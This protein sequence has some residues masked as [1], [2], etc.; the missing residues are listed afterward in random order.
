MAFAM[1]DLKWLEN[2]DS[3]SHWLS[4]VGIVDLVRGQTNLT[5]IASCG[6]TDDLLLN[7]F[8]TLNQFLPE[9][10][11]PGSVFNNLDRFIEASISA[12]SL[13]ALFERDANSLPTLLKIFSV[14]QFLADHLIRDPESFDLLR[15]TEGQAVSRASLL[16][17]ILTETMAMI[18][19][20][21][22]MRT[23]RHC[24]QR[25]MLRIAY[26]DFIGRHSLEVVTEQLS[27]LAE[28]LMEAALQWVRQSLERKKPPPRDLTGHPIRFTVLALGKLGGTEL[29]YSSDID[30]IFLADIENVERQRASQ[31]LEFFER[32]A[33]QFIK[34]LAEK[35]AD[36][37]VYRVDMR[38]RPLGSNGSLVCSP[39]VAFNYYENLGRTWERQAY[40]KAR[41][42]AGN[43][44]LGEKF[45]EE[46]QPWIFRRYL[47]RADIAGIGV[48]KRRIEKRIS[49]E[50][51]TELNVKLGPGGIRD[52]EFV[53]QF[54]Q[55][56]NGGDLKSIRCRNT[57]QAI[58]RLEQAS[59]LNQQEA[60]ILD[61][62][63]R[64]LRQVEHFLQIMFDLQTH[65]L[66]DTMSEV[67][68]LAL[69]MGFKD[70]ELKRA[71]E[72]LRSMLEEK[73]ERIRRIVDHLLHRAFGDQGETA[74]ETDLIL[75]PD[76]LPEMID[77]VLI[78]H[79]FSRPYDAYQRLLE[80]SKEKFSFLSTRR[81]RH[82]LA[83]IAPP[84]L[85]AISRTPDPDRTLSQLSNVS[86]SLGGKAVL[87][88]LF[89]FNPPSMQLYVRLCACSPY[90]VELLTG[91]PGMIDELLDSL[92]LDRLP[93]QEELEIQLQ[94]LC[95]NAADI[96]PILLSF[97]NSH[98]LRVGTRDILGKESISNTHRA[99][100]DIAE[101]TLR[102]VVQ[103]EYQRLSHRYGTPTLASGPRQGEECGFTIIALGKLGG[104][105]PN[106]HSDLDILFLFE[107][108]GS[109]V[110]RGPVRKG[111]TTTNRHFYNQ[112]SQRLI[113]TVSK[114]TPWGRLYEIDAR[115]RPTGQS[116]PL[117]IAVEDLKNYFD[118][119]QGQ[120]WERQALC[121]ARPIYGPPELQAKTMAVIRSIITDIEW[122]ADIAK[123]I[124]EMRMRLQQS[125]TP[126]NIKR[127]VGGT[128][129]IEFSIQALQIKHARHHSSIIIPG[130][131]AALKPL[132]EIGAL[133][134]E[135]A[136]LMDEGYRF[137]RGIESGLRL[138]NTVARHDFPSEG[139][140]LRTLE[141]L[142]GI[143]DNVPIA[144][145]CNQIRRQNR[146]LITE[147]F[148]LFKLE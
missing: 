49:Q 13:G 9:T 17:E 146:L 143:H 132:V 83:A 56:L 115:L 105:E 69:R 127:G 147:L 108:D 77:K 134:P 39:Q 124:Y 135:H 114:I 67:R 68:K 70:S 1:K 117:A 94:E 22:M 119:G 28:A 111:D 19:E 93:Q 33:T 107:G 23:L 6:M 99:L 50:N 59:I 43:Q 7:L 129:D 16:D 92:L 63:Y 44:E 113:Q 140:E 91:N 133:T 26:G 120:L 51:R 45:L 18:D 148:E 29:N 90:L 79:G 109:T 100:S 75:D 112:L 2:V 76:P 121:K 3:S 126:N 66:P 27:F 12:Q 38:L 130:T 61:D 4:Q 30:L 10:G 34:A 36:G 106:Y 73:T 72:I 110:Q 31:A 58:E 60:S 71:E 21:Q 137:L 55:L 74:E 118:E 20:P 144:E 81:C 53:V 125:A 104:R 57:L 98:H 82:F 116:G 65:S 8:S 35:T 41:V 78:R 15:I 54:L 97:R 48:L 25:E 52:I 141:F 87:W 40:L 139:E 122:S 145:R 14:S 103:H 11:D 142:L 131:L 136:W 138:M 96:E 42:V 84:L 85:S 101:V 123:Q 128:L 102:Q 37:R 32:M 62:G 86:N 95:K 80:L 47:S 64:L 88:E 24:R 46:L 89:S 5:R